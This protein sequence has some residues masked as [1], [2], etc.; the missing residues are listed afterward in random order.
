MAQ[1]TSCG[2]ELDYRDRLC[3]SCGAITERG[4]SIPER[5]GLFV[6]RLVDQIAR[7]V[8][9]AENRG[10]VVTLGAIAALMLLV[11][12]NNPLS[13][14]IFGPSDQL[15]DLPQFNAD[16]SPDFE[17]YKDIFHTDEAEYLVT[18]S[19]NV[20]NYPTSQDTRV[21]GTLYNGE[22][23]TARQVQPFDGTTTWY[24]LS[25]G[26]YVWGG[27]LA[28]HD[29]ASDLG[30]D[31]MLF[32]SNLQGRW[33]SLETCRGAQDDEIVEI[34]P[35]TIFF[36]RAEAD[37]LSGTLIGYSEDEIGPTYRLRMSSEGQVRET[38]YIITPVANPR[39]ILI[40]QVPSPINT[41]DRYYAEDTPCFRVR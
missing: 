28:R 36:S 20:R 8:G 10:Q 5:L 38:F 22:I 34:S 15:P 6:G 30:T 33:L 27:N 1:C 37:N 17:S 11:A 12:T 3:S 26:G 39:S 14:A 40:E 29:D 25:G 13:K 4:R 18:S 41:P 32:P 24:R 23:V 9:N 16:G 7:F 21:I 35:G 2:H 31:T 19:A